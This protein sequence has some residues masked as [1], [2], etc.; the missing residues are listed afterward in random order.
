MDSNMPQMCP[1]C[2]HPAH[3]RDD[4]TAIDVFNVACERCGRFSLPG[5]LH[6][7]FF[8]L[9][10]SPSTERDLLPYLSAY[11]RQTSDNGERVVLDPTNWKEFALAHKDTAVSR[12]LFNLLALIAQ[13]T[14][15]GTSTKILEVDAPLLDCLDD[16]ELT[17]LLNTQVELGYIEQVHGPQTA[18]LKAKGWEQIQAAIVNGIPGK[19]FVAMSFDESLAEPYD[20]GIYLAV[21]T[22][23]KMDP[24]RIDRVH[25]NEKICDKLI[26]EIRTS[27]FLIADVTLQR[28]GV[29]FEAGFAMGLGRPVIWTCRQDDMKNVHFDTR[30]YSHVVWTD[31]YDL[32]TKL[33]DR[34]KAT[35]PGVT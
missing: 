7:T 25:H 22:D 18:R 1:I 23:C 20:H 24:L 11:T 16:L 9:H 32:R 27:H 34:I 26:A 30:Q 28:A 33:A 6:F 29:Y 15:P 12:K 8:E 5:L 2:A 14:R 10:N 13:R 21:K 19:C 17:Y 31:P 4:D 3:L 35:I